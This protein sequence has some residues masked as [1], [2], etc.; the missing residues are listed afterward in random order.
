MHGTKLFMHVLA[1]FMHNI[2]DCTQDIADCMHEI[3]DF[4]HA[5]H[6]TCTKPSIS[7]MT[8]H[9]ACMTLQLAGVMSFEVVKVM[10][11]TDTQAAAKAEGLGGSPRSFFHDDEV[12]AQ[13]QPSAGRYCAPIAIYPQ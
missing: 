6:M 8:L 13:C 9:I 10:D 7:C 11:P 5:F 4:M 2:A 1:H 12:S 3:A